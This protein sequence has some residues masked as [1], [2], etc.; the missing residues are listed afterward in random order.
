MPL[1]PSGRDGGGRVR[2]RFVGESFQRLPTQRET[3]VNDGN[4]GRSLN[5]HNNRRGHPTKKVERR[6]D[7]ERYKE[8]IRETQSRSTETTFKQSDNRYVPY[9]AQKENR[10]R[11]TPRLPPPPRFLP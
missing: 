1:E 6:Q 9:V 7:E 3:D 5:S 10:Q 11:D 2:K 4:Q 8:R